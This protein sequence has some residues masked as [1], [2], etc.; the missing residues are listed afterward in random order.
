MGKPT[1]SL[2]PSR[3]VFSFPVIYYA[4]IL[5]QISILGVLPHT[6]GHGFDIAQVGKFALT[7]SQMERPIH[8]TIM[9]TETSV[10]SL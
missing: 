7:D 4:D 3:S 8:Y 5:I 1:V 6:K 2:L 10:V 9:N